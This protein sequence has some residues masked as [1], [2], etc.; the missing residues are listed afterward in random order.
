MLLVTSPLDKGEDP[1][2]LRCLDFQVQPEAECVRQLRTQVRELLLGHGV[3]DKL[4]DGVELGLDEVLMN[5]LDHGKSEDAE[6]VQLRVFLYAD[7][8]CFEVRDR[9]DGTAEVDCDSGELPDEDAESGRGLF[10]I[11]HT[12]DE[13]SFHAREGGGTLVR[14]MKRL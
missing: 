10:L 9:G 7:R 8:L 4:V 1:A 6:A 13:V 5:A 2:P 14:M 11:H 3:G 12:M